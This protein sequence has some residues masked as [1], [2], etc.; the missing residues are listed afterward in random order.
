MTSYQIN[1]ISNCALQ[2]EFRDASSLQPQAESCDDQLKDYT[3]IESDDF[4]AMALAAESALTG[5]FEN[6]HLY[7]QGSYSLK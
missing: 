1:F 5:V 3:G 4:G 6:E 2:W 7:L